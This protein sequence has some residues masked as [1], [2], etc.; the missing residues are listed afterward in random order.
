MKQYE[1]QKPGVFDGLVFARNAIGQFY[2]PPGDKAVFAHIRAGRTWEA[3][4]VPF[5]RRYSRLGSTVIDCG[6]YIGLHTVTMARAVGK[7]GRVVALDARAEAA[8]VCAANCELNALGNVTVLAKGVSDKPRTLFF[9]ALPS[10]RDNTPAAFDNP[11][12]VALV[13]EP[14]EDGVEVPC[15]SIDSLELT[16]VS[17]MKIDTEG[18]ELPT[19][20]GALDTISRCR[21]VMAVEVLGGS[22]DVPAR[23]KRLWR[24]LTTLDEAGTPYRV[25]R[26][27]EQDF[28]LVPAE[29]TE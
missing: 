24:I 15:V 11:G 8:A 22:L 13:A 21:P 29:P 7:E 5:L 27:W 4:L 28:L 6:C 23:K 16:D 10:L 9:P 19:I 1:E 25:E 20:K 14:L 26:G 18:G 2:G 3:H 17:M 12:G